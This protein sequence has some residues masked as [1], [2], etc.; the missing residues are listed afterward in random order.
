MDREIKKLVDEITQLE[1]QLNHL[2]EIENGD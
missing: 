1:N 2:K